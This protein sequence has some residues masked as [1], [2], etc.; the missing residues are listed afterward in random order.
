VSYRVEVRRAAADELAKLP[1]GLRTG[2]LGRIASL[3]E[4]PRPAGSRALQEGAGAV[5]RLRTWDRRVAFTVDD[6]AGLVRVW[7]IGH[8]GTFYH[9]Y[10]RRQ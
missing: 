8:R 5:R 6:Q 2:I 3:A 4:D 7:M 1:P 10:R 9:R